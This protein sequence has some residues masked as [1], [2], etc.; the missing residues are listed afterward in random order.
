M[1]SA[2]HTSFLGTLYSRF[3]HP[4]GL[5]VIGT[6]K[7]VLESVVLSKIVELMGPELGA[8]IGD[9]LVWYSISGHVCFEL[10]DHRFC[11]C[12]V[13][14]I[15]FKEVRE[16]VDSHEVTLLLVFEEIC[17]YLRPRG[18]GYG[19]AD[20]G[21]FGCFGANCGQTLHLEMWSFI[22]PFMFGQ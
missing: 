4:I 8:L 5:M 20:E 18:V 3:C 14:P 9:Q 13:Q 7:C 12:V 6:H 2:T 16:I 10:Q 1:A 19:V 17:S 22:S 11:C 21:F 15:D